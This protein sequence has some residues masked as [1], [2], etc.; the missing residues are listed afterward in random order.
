MLEILDKLLRHHVFYFNFTY[1]E[2]CAITLPHLVLNKVVLLVGKHNWNF[3]LSRQQLCCLIKKLLLK[4]D[5][6]FVRDSMLVVTIT[7][8]R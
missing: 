8:V 2:S 6:L 5:T 3:S 7:V 4:L 1:V